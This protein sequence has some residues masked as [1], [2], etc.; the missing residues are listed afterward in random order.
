MRK[1]GD[2]R[3]RI[4]ELDVVIFFILLF[5]VLIVIYPFYNAFLVSVTTEKEYLATPFMIWPKEWT[6]DSYATVLSEQSLWS[7]YKVTIFLTTVGTLIQ[8]FFT[9]ITGYAMSRNGW[10]K[11]Y[12]EF[13]SRDDVF[14]RG[15]YPVL[16]SDKR[17]RVIR[18]YM[19]NDHSG[20]DKHLQYVAHQ[21]LFSGITDRNGRVRE[22][23][24]GE[25]HYYFL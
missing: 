5:I 22:N 7:G 21:K 20:S 15:T 6:F 18:F 16:L 25:R 13:Y 2:Y 1:S 19:G 11:F 9:V 10:E 14:R 8:L 23:R 4:T 3:S 24:R 17:R 12:Y